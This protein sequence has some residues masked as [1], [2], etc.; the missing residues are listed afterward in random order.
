MELI[1]QQKLVVQLC[2]DHALL[3]EFLAAPAQVT[4]REG[5]T[6]GAES[7]AKLNPGQLRQFARLLRMRRLEEAGTALPLTRRALGHR[8][9]ELFTAYALQNPPPGKRLGQDAIAFVN[10]LQQ[11]NPTKPLNPVWLMSLA[12]YE[13]A[14]VEVE[15][16]G[17]RKLL[18]RKF[19]HALRRLL[20]AFEADGVPKGDFS[21]WT[22]AVWCSSSSG[23]QPRHWLW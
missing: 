18:V 7:L 11:S 6:V 2:T 19:P 20:K 17:Q 8:F 3:E 4:T 12:S 5:L 22:L 10:Y 16:L 15:W 23:R 1:R 13:A 21:G 14:R 9:A